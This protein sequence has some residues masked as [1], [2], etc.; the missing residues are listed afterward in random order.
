MKKISLYNGISS[1]FSAISICT[2]LLIIQTRIPILK[3]ET[4]K[5]FLLKYSDDRY[6]NMKKVLKSKFF[7]FFFRLN[8]QVLHVTL[9]FVRYIFNGT[10]ILR[11]R[12]NREI[13]LLTFVL[14]FLPNQNMLY[15]NS[16]Y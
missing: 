14:E 13:G 7:S 3:S 10:K 8:F 16:L 5:K 1:D 12:L 2:F 15:R 6:N 9:K 4:E 11:I